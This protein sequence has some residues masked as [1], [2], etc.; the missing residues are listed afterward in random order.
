MAKRAPWEIILDDN[1]FVHLD[2]I[3]TREHSVILDV[4]EQQLLYE[5]TVQTRNRKP[6]RIPN[7]VG[8]TWELRCSK[9]NRYR[10]FYDIDVEA[11]MVVVLAIGYKVGN[12][13]FIGGEELSL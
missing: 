4:I 8:S 10:I 9:N 5:A 1:V 6:M 7:T 12:R 2:A 13:L 11:R 3:P